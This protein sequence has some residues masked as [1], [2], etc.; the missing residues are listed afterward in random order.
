MLITCFVSRLRI[1]KAALPTG[2]HAPPGA[3]AESITITITSV[4]L[5]SFYC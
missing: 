1:G 2:S 3:A 5:F 4:F